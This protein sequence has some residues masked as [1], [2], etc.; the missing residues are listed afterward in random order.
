MFSPKEK[1]RDK[2]A[3]TCT[4]MS[5]SVCTCTSV[6]PDACKLQ[7]SLKQPRETHTLTEVM[8][9]RRKCRVAGQTTGCSINEGTCIEEKQTDKKVV[10]Y[11]QKSKQTKTNIC[12]HTCTN[13]MYVCMYA[14]MRSESE[15]ASHS[16]P[17]QLKGVRVIS[18]CVRVCALSSVV[19]VQQK[20]DTFQHISE[21]YTWYDYVF[22]E[23]K[24]KI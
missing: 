2:H 15:S 12:I 3:Y 17:P 16:A 6:G 9:A 10:V 24:G 14:C 7:C 21:A 20:T 23:R 18:A 11:T 4:C 19:H 8:K 1:E 13:G 5:L 22:T